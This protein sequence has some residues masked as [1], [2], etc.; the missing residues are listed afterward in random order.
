MNNKL[1]VNV[2]DLDLFRKLY[3]NEKSVLVK[4]YDAVA[5]WYF[6]RINPNENNIELHSLG[7]YT[8]DGRFTFYYS[9]GNYH[10]VFPDLKGKMILNCYKLWNP[11]EEITPQ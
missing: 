2:S 4:H 11:Q 7:Q 8:C 10:E 1:L 5:R 3:P 9:D 6:N